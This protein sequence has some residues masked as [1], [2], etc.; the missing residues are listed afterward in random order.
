MNHMIHRGFIWLVCTCLISSSVIGQSYSN[1]LIPVAVPKTLPSIAT[2]VPAGSTQVSLQ[3]KT[4]ES[5]ALYYKILLEQGYTLDYVDSLHLAND[6]TY[7]RFTPNVAPLVT[8]PEQNCPQGIPVCQNSYTQANSYTGFG[9]QEVYNTCLLAHEQCSVWYIFTI[10]PGGT[11]FDFTINTTHDYDWAIYDLTAIGGCANVPT[12]SPVSCN[13]SGTYGNTGISTANG[14]FSNSTNAAGIPWNADLT[15]TVGHTYAM[16]IDN[17]TQDALGYVLTFGGTA[18]L[19]NNSVPTL[20]SCTNDCNNTVTINTSQLIKCNTIAA[21]GSDFVISGPA[22]MSV[23]SASGIGCTAP[24][25]ANSTTSQ[26]QL[27][28]SAPAVSGTYTITVQNGTDGNT[29]TNYCGNNSVPVGNTITFQYLAPLSIT[30]SPATIC[31]GNSS[32]LTL[33]GGPAGGATYAW[34]PAG[35]TSA[36]AT[37][38][39]VSTTTYVET[40]TYGGCVA[41]PSTTITVQPTPVVSITPMNPVLCS[42]TQVLSATSTDNGTNCASCTYSWTGSYTGT[43]SSTPAEGAGTYTCVATTTGGCPSSPEVSTISLASASTGCNILYVQPSSTG[44]GDGSTPANSATI[45]NAVASAQCGGVIKMSVGVYTLSAPLQPNSYVTIEGGFNTTFTTKTSDMSGGTNSTTIRRNNTVD[46]ATTRVT[47][48]SYAAGA[49]GFRLQDLRIEMPGAAPLASNPVNTA[50]NHITNYAV[51]LGSGCSNYNIVR[52]Y[53]DAGAGSNGITGGSGANGSTGGTSPG[54]GC[55]TGGTGAGTGVRQG[56]TGGDA[57]GTNSAGTGCNRAD[58]AGGSAG[59]GGAAG[60]S[61]TTSGMSFNGSC[62]NNI[63]HT[64]VGK[65]GSNGANGSAGSTGT[66][67]SYAAGFF[68]PGTNGGNGTDGGGGGGGG[69]GASNDDAGNLY[70][71]CSGGGGGSGGFGGTGG[72]SGGGAFGVFSIAQGASAV[73]SDCQILTTAGSGGAGGS[74][75]TGGAGGYLTCGAAQFGGSPINL[76]GAGGA[77]GTGG[78]GGVG[79]AGD[80]CPVCDITGGTTKNIL[81]I[82]N[83]QTLTAQPIIVAGDATNNNTNCTTINMNMTTA[84]ALHVWGGAAPLAGALSPQ[85]VAYTTTGRKTVTM[86]NGTAYTYTDFNNMITTAPSAGSILPS[87]TSVCTGNSITVSSS[88]NGIPGFTF[89]WSINPAPP[90][91]VTATIV[92]PTSGSTVINLTNTNTTAQTITVQLIVTSQCCGALT[93][94]TQTITINPEPAPPTAAASGNP[95]CPGSGDVL[96]ITS[97]TAGLTFNW[98]NASTGGTLLAT[99]T[100]YSVTPAATTT[101]Y[102]DATNST[103]CTSVPRTSITITV[104]ATPAPATTGAS[105]CGP[106]SLT[107]SV[108]TPVSGATYNW[109]SSSCTGLLQSSPSPTYTTP[110]ISVTTTYYVTITLP[111]CNESS[112]NP[113][114]ATINAAPATLTWTGGGVAGAG[115]WFDPNNWGGC[116]PTC[117]T[118]VI[119]PNTAGLPITNPPSIGVQATYNAAENPAACNTITLVSGNSLTFSDTKAELDIC[120]DFNHSGT[121]TMSSQGK[122]VFIST[123]VAQNYNRTGTGAGDLYDVVLNNTSGTA[124]LTILDGAGNQDMN[125]ATNGTFSFVSGMVITQN[126]RTLCIKNTSSTALNGYGLTAYVYGNVRRYLAI[127]TSY[128]FPVGNATSYQLMNLNFTALTGLNYVT[129][130]FDN[131]ANATGTGMPVADGGGNYTSLLNNGGPSVGVGSTNGNAGVWTVMPDNY[132]NASTAFYEMI[133][134]GRNYSNATTSNVSHLKRNTFCPGIWYVNGD[135]GGYKSGTVAGN[136]VTTDRDVMNGFSQFVIA[137]NANPLP[138]ELSAFEAT[139]VDNHVKINWVSASETNNAF[140]T[141][142]RSCE[143]TSS[144]QTVG[145]V[146]GAGNSSSAI[147]YSYIDSTFPGGTCYYRLKQTDINGSSNTLKT[148]ALNC[149]EELQ[150]SLINIF[151]NPA[152][153]ELNILFNSDADGLVEV[154]LMDMLGQQ[155][156]IKDVP[157]QLGLNQ[158]KLDMSPFSNAVYFVRINNSTKTFVRKVTKQQ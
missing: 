117:G 136:V 49:S 2:C 67:F 30:P 89:S 75:G 96:S 100:T 59:G 7:R 28:L 61:V 97:A 142:E 24:V 153:N 123:T 122:I 3:A 109:Y 119:I 19:V 92:S 144:F 145:T 108:T 51:Y 105:G 12:S 36:N 78:S 8:G 114:T 127:S 27:S 101:Y 140:Y 139:C 151:P 72:S 134:Y 98:Y 143:N 46:A 56:G 141:I 90:A 129:V 1:G 87:S 83:P 45:Q 133:L 102:V 11:T 76:G 155:L 146:P 99:G 53:I 9:Y 42:G 116:L 111:G 85:T 126:T 91:G 54:P 103:G 77:G 20:A 35:G 106:Q 14:G 13:F 137:I 17:Y 69:G 156:I 34:S 10:Q 47:A 60:G 84:G 23:L 79:A 38:T 107:V 31:A 121:V 58:G 55:G 86:N 18:S 148:I 40:V 39:P 32:T 50:G 138:I 104:T 66:A 158:T 4:A 131:P 157:A 95:I 110:V 5:E 88:L 68:V 26:V 135:D 65:P 29:L 71:G 115:N 16:I 22:A 41:H 125:I 128:D 154:C 124:T 43:G 44:T 149:K 152:Q 150:F 21:N 64:N 63:A 37:V 74:G 94:I 118:N 80:N 73:V 57:G 147:Q 62:D 25:G 15:V 132:A 112:C 52:C 113:V 93:A 81:S 82:T 33:N 120:G 6:K 130:F 70:Y 48:F